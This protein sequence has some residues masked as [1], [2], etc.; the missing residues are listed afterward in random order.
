M[1]IF[2]QA[3]SPVAQTKNATGAVVLWTTANGIKMFEC[4]G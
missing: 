3:L 2:V 4:I 1:Y